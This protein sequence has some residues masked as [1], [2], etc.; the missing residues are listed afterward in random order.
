MAYRGRALFG[1]IPLIQPVGPAFLQKS[2]KEPISTSA[3]NAL[4][5]RDFATGK[6][7]LL[8]DIKGLAERP[9]LWRMV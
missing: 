2:R 7:I 3:E 9:G 4:W 1:A 8:I 6:V 5:C